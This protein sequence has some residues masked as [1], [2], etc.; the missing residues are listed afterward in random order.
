MTIDGKTIRLTS[1]ISWENKHGPLA[2]CKGDC[3]TPSIECDLGALA[4]GD[5]T[6]EYGE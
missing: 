1:E 6:V 2:K 5:Y 3:G 4:G